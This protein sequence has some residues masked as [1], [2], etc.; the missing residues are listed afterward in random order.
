MHQARSSGLAHGPG[1][2]VRLGGRLRTGGRGWHGPPGVVGRTVAR[3]C[4]VGR[5]SARRG[6]RRRIP[7]SPAIVAPYA[8]RAHCRQRGG[9]SVFRA[10]VSAGR[11]AGPAA[12]CLRFSPGPLP[13]V[14]CQRPVEAEWYTRFD[15]FAWNERSGRTQIDSEHGTLYTLGYAR[16]F[17][18]DRFRGELFTG[19]MNFSGTNWV[20]DPADST[21]T[22][23][24]V[25]GEY[26]WLWDMSLPGCPPATLFA[27]VGTRFWIRDIKDGTVL[28]TGDF[29]TGHQE[30]WWTIYPYVG[31]EKRWPCNVR[32]GDLRPRTPGLHR[33]YLS[34]LRVGRGDAAVSAGGPYRPGGVWVSS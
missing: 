12:G 2:H 26:E 11:A 4:V 16:C 9:R 19:T 25:R 3:Q 28:S 21:T 13:S 34:V 1:D 30:N 24:G 33:L 23:L 14:F 32:R 6:K 18:A 29:F 5:R 10:T 7:A 27:G 22:Y 17:G 31:L 20:G 8:G 15:Y